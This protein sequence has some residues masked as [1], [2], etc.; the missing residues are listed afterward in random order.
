M[1]LNGLRI[2]LEQRI[3]LNAFSPSSYSISGTIKN[4]TQMNP[5]TAIPLT[6]APVGRWAVKNWG[7]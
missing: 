2:G 4:T 6:E 5:E 7:T 3:T 1:Q